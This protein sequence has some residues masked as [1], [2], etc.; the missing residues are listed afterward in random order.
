[1]LN[2]TSTDD[3]ENSNNYMISNTF[4]FGVKNESAVFDGGYRISDLPPD[5]CDQGSSSVSTVVSNG[6]KENGVS[7]G[8]NHHLS[9]DNICIT[10]M[11]FVPLLPSAITFQNQ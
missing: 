9:F 4:L 8:V 10:Q 3:D 2:D 6:H 1:M 11:P 7:N 5:I